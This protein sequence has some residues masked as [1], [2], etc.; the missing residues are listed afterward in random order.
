VCVQ[1]SGRNDILREIMRGDLNTLQF[2]GL[3]IIIRR[4]GIRKLGDMTIPSRPC[5]K[6]FYRG[7]VNTL[8][9]A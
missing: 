4:K 5:R 8:T 3:V 9:N 6:P 2:V 1:F 7:P